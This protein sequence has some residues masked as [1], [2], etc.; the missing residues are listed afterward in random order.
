MSKEM[1]IDW[2]KPLNQ[3]G[4][5]IDW[6]KPLS[7]SAPKKNVGLKE[8]F[9]M[10]YGPKG[11]QERRD[12]EAQSRRQV[13]KVAAN[14]GLGAL[15]EI[16]NW[17]PNIADAL[18]IN[19]ERADEGFTQYA[20]QIENPEIAQ[21]IGASIPHIYGLTGAYKSLG[22]FTPKSVL[23]RYGADIAKLGGLEYLFSD[24]DKKLSSAA[25]AGAAAAILNPLMAIGS[26]IG[27]NAPGNL[28]KKNL[29][30]TTQKEAALASSEKV[31]QELLRRAE[32]EGAERFATG[33]I[34]S[35]R[36]AEEIQG[37]LGQQFPD[38]PIENLQ[39]LTES[40]KGARGEIKD[41]YQKM[42]EGFKGSQA[43]QRAI[44][45]PVVY[46]D[47]EQIGLK[48]MPPELSRDIEKY[49]GKKNVT[50]AATDIIHGAV[51]AKTEYLGAEGNIQN[52]LDISK[53]ARDESLK[54]REMARN[55]NATISEK[56]RYTKLANQ[57][58]DLQRKVDESIVG[59]LAPQEA[60]QYQQIQDFFKKY[61]I[62]FREK[63]LLKKAVSNR[64][65]VKTEDFYQSLVKE[66]EPELMQRLLDKHPQVQDAIARFDLRAADFTSVKSIDKILS[67]QR[68]SA[69]PPAVTKDLKALRSE[70]QAKEIY[71]KLLPEVGKKEL[72]FIKKYPDLNKVF[73]ERPDL[74]MPFDNIRQ[75]SLRLKEVQSQLEA[76]GIERREAEKILREYRESIRGLGS[77]LSTVMGSK[78]Y[79][80][81]RAISSLSD[82]KK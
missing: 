70:L 16:A 6:S 5:D 3:G 30:E 43:G 76:A 53:K 49:I 77:L 36:A 58:G 40:L 9:S 48:D 52:Y 17:P 27:K 72:A 15:Q 80:G 8:M 50:E 55:R 66:N 37:R 75:E 63:S 20:P 7:K 11:R 68:A 56:E 35:Q 32:L 41:T 19:L 28:L 69:L 71:E 47:V 21:G 59:S 24:P 4:D 54:Y 65:T 78:V 82:I 31:Q 51:P 45:N 23:G 18:G 25:G 60:A 1:E 74:R 10:A 12:F 64:P 14:V 67:G 33:S 73:T 34:E 46:K 62:P 39:Q 2:S 42:Y 79:Y 13:P 81:S 22:K 61:E 38:T 26:Q 29:A 44:K 57:Y